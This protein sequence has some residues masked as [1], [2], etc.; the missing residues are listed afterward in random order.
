MAN[1]LEN[2]IE[3]WRNRGVIGDD[4]AR[5]LRDDVRASRAK[6]PRKPAQ[7]FSFL[8]IVVA[9][10]A[11]SFA[12]AILMFISANWDAIPRLAKVAGIMMLI[13][14]GLV[15]GAL[16]RGRARRHGP[17]LAEAFY[18]VGGA[19]YVGGVAL[20]GQMYH[21]PGTLGEAMFG[22]AIGLGAAGLLVCSHVLGVAALAAILWWYLQRPQPD[23][24]LTVDFALFAGFCAVGGGVAH[25]R[26]AHWMRRAAVAAGLVGLLP[27]LLEVL[28]TVVDAY[29]ALPDTVRLSIWLVVL[30][31]SA[32]VTAAERYRPGRLRGLPGFAR[33]RAGAAFGCGLFALAVLHAE[34]GDLLPL[35]AVGPLTLAFA[36][37]V[38]LAHG[39]RS[40]PIRWAG[41][42]VF[43][44]EILF[45]YGETVA[46]L[47]GTAGL[48]FAVG[49]TLTLI[50]L[51]I[52]RFE[53]RLERPGPERLPDG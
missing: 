21:L 11:V 39:A 18:L 24:L 17:R 22:F 47:L 9:F 10:A 31:A 36:L 12:A 46:S 23:N 43:V 48:F 51:V 38:L 15:G 30:A 27:F 4:T 40:A 53:R 49:V 16:A 52:V 33:P 19:A 29:A 45:L 35:L 26:G 28:R 3:D 6:S 1:R 2:R 34:T 32:L 42:V 5:A 44:G 14:A 13:A 25:W 37:L 7:A 41:Y 50:A 20:V 8:R